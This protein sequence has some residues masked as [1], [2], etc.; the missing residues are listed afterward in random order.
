MM[1][2]KL[3]IKGYKLKEKYFS[4]TMIKIIIMMMILKNIKLQMII[5]LKWEESKA[6]KIMTMMMI[7][8]NIM[9]QMILNF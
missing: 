3:G 6:G 2:I 1:L 4:I 9:I 5:N 7:L 8:I